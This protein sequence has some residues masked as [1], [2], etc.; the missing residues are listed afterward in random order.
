MLSH[1][2]SQIQYTY[3]D[4]Y[5]FMMLFNGGIV[6]SYILYTQYLHLRNSI[7]ALILPGIF[8][9][10]YVLIM[11]GFLAK[12]PHEIIESAKIDGARE[13]RIFAIIVIPLSAPALATLGLFISFGYG[14]SWFP[15]TVIY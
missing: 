8:S 4:L 12:I 13:L 14:N 3:Y 11:K 5:F 10:F 15:G 6:P 1:V 9:P 2:D 7:W